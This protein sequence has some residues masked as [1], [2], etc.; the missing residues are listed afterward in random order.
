MI[1]NSFEQGNKRSMLLPSKACHK[2]HFQI[3]KWMNS[4]TQLSH[5]SLYQLK[6]CM[7][8]GKSIKCHLSTH[9]WQ[10]YALIIEEESLDY[11]IIFCRD[12]FCNWVPL[13][14]TK[15]QLIMIKKNCSD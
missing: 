14:L 13:R 10:V 1:F 6:S 4:E 5:I 12:L 15:I 3:P 8:A 2:V 9:S 7:L 11:I